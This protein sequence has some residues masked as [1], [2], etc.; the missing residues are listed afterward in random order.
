MPNYGP[1][2]LVPRRTVTADGNVE[3]TQFPTTYLKSAVFRLILQAAGDDGTDL[4]N[5]RIQHSND[6]TTWSDFVSFTQLA[7]DNSATI[8]SPNVED[9]YWSVEAGPESEMRTPAAG[10]LAAGTVVQGP[11]GRHLRVAWDIDDNSDP[12]FTFI[13]K[14]DTI[15]QN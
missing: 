14:A 1:H 12:S 15:E 6:G 4:L 11:I 3:L 9:A 10:T 7:G 5:V 2:T 13:L 8:A